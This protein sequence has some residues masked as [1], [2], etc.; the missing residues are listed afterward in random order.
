MLA[1]AFLVVRGGFLEVA[2]LAAHIAHAHQ[3]VVVLGLQFQ[4]LFEAIFGEVHIAV[5]ERLI[6][7]FR[8]LA[9]R[10]VSLGKFVGKVNVGW[11]FLR[12]E[13]GRH[14]CNQFFSTVVSFCT[15]ASA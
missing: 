11:G 10:I 1:K 5:L 8:Q 12:I 4:Q 6:A 14:S 7:F 13:F 2:H 15:M 3:G 9:D